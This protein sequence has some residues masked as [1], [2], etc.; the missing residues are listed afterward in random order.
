[1]KDVP[2]WETGT[3]YGEPVFHN[4]AGQFPP[5]SNFAYYVHS[6]EKDMMKRL[7]EKLKH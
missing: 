5:I 2:G 6:T 1:M 4:K 7:N 3:L